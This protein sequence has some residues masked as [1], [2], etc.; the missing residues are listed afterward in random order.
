MD[1]QLMRQARELI[2]DE[3]RGCSFG[4]DDKQG[5]LERAEGILIALEAAGLVINRKQQE[6]RSS[7]TGDVP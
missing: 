7:P 2:A 3:I 5:A 1:I 4:F 6:G